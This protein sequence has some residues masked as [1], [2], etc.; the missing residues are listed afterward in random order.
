MGNEQF[1]DEQLEDETLEDKIKKGPL[2]NSA[3]SDEMKNL[4]NWVSF[5]PEGMAY[6]V[7]FKQDLFGNP[8]FYSSWALDWAK[9]KQL[10]QHF[11]DDVEIDDQDEQINDDDDQDEQINN[12][13]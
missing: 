3:I 2:L 9:E 7:F 10:T 11:T 1:D 6:M 13:E 5:N 8:T 4:L 12:E